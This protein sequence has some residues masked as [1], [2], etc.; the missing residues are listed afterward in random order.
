M[1]ARRNGGGIEEFG[2]F[3]PPKLWS[4]KTKEGWIFS[5]NLI[6]LGGFVRLK[7]EHDGDTHK[8]SFG[9]ASLGAK[10]KIMLAGVGMNLLAAFVLL[11]IL[12]WVGMPQLVNNQYTVKSDTKVVKNEDLIGYIEPGS[13]AQKAG[14]ATSDQLLAII[15][16]HGAP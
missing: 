16:A 11:T 14:L 15:P 2:I 1:V 5:I 4:H 9:A 13:P 8:G 12:A 3:F 6:P 10:T 7:G